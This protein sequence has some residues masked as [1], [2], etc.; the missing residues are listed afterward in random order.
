MKQKRTFI[1]L[2]LIVALLCLGIAYAAIGNI[3]LKVSGDVTATTSNENFK[4]K[5]ME[6]TTTAGT[7]TIEATVE[8]DLNATINVSGLTTSGQ[9]AT[10]T[11]TIKNTSPENLTANL[12]KSISHTNTD[13]FEVTATIANE[14]IEKESTTTMTVTVKLL[15]TPATVADETAAKDTITINIDATA[16][17]PTV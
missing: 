12:T 3:Q 14:S 2:L 6:E 13:W 7:G 11:Y 16:V 15:K 8:D 4:V 1:T 10:A 9:T 5:F 17:Q